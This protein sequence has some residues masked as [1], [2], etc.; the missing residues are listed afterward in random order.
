MI[1]LGVAGE[2]SPR[3]STAADVGFLGR[4]FDREGG[5]QLISPIEQVGADR[6]H[7]LR[8]RVQL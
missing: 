5:V 2:L 1:A 6:T 8:P 4:S 7:Q 3:F